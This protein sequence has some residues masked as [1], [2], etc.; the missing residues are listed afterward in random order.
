MLIIAWVPLKYK[1]VLICSV[2]HLVPFEVE[3]W[4]ECMR[5]DCRVA[6]LCHL[7]IYLLGPVAERVQRATQC[8]CCCPLWQTVL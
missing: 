6:T 4:Q 2:V 8:L 7:L 5:M 1:E 3:K